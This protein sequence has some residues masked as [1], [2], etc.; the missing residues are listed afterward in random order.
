M[1]TP[2]IGRRESLDKGTSTGVPSTTKIKDTAGSHA[3][4]TTR[5]KGYYWIKRKIYP[6]S[7]SYNWTSSSNT[8]P[9]VSLSNTKLY[10][11]R[12]FTKPLQHS[13]PKHHVMM[14]LEE[15]RN[16]RFDRRSSRSSA[17]HLGHRRLTDKPARFA[18]SGLS[19]G[20]NVEDWTVYGA[21]TMNAKPP[22]PS[23]TR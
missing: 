2:T 23:W 13:Q 19:A 9:N 8:A 16:T 12:T 22:S 7:Q 4:S 15:P 6:T 17:T 5:M 11:S 1:S 18:Q 21:W 10:K 3:E 20:C 14:P